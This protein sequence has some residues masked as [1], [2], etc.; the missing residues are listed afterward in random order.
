MADVLDVLTRLPEHHRA[1]LRWFATHAGEEVLWPKPLDDGTRLAS[2]AKGIYK[3]EWTSYALSIRQSLHSPY[4]DQEPIV[5]ADGNWSYFYFQENIEPS[6]RDAAYTNRGLVACWQDGVPVGVM[7][8]RSEKSPVIYKVLGLAIV[9]GW[10]GGFFILE[11]VPPSGR[12]RDLVSANQ[13]DWTVKA[14]E[15]T[16]ESTPLAGGVYDARE[17]IVASIVRR[18][19]QPEFRQRILQAYEGRCA[20]TACE[21][22]EV[23]EAAHIVPYFG[24]ASN[25]PSNGLLLRAD[26]HTL[27]DL[28]MIAIDTKRLSVLVSPL[29]DR[30]Y[31]HIVGRTLRETRD[32]SCAPDKSALDQHRAWSGL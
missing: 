19:G 16:E 6:E 24:P 5:R 25:N 30:S 27:F 7:R 4:P 3:P 9:A 31:A 14:A 32:R 13:L 2:K 17:R 28:G 20:V 1:A 12:M 21:T 22:V 15:A 11:G 23:L 29:V 8:Q 26:V 10:Q 18:R